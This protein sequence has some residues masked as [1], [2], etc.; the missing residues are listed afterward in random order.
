[1]SIK[2]TI[3]TTIVALA[4]VAMIAPG[5]AQGVTIEELLAQI[6]ILQ[7]Q[8]LV[9]QGGTTGGCRARRP[10]AAKAVRS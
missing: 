9:L 3:I 10:V 5:V 4:L 8:L 6:A 1:M 2:R 7:Q